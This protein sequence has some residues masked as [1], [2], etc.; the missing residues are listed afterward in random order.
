[1]RAL[2][3]YSRCSGNYSDFTFLF[4][5]SIRTVKLVFAWDDCSGCCYQL[6]WD[7]SKSQFQIPLNYWSAVNATLHRSLDSHWNM[8]ILLTPR[9]VTY[10][11]NQQQFYLSPHFALEFDKRL[12]PSWI[13]LR[14]FT[15]AAC[16]P[17]I[18]LTKLTTETMRH[19][20]ALIP[21]QLPRLLTF[22]SLLPI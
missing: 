13:N 11:T 9:K 1:M 2:Y 14:L 19:N 4:G 22:A 17:W 15:D 12:F 21:I 7:C 16:T 18:R 3:F 8:S 5:I 10:L 6:T 20:F